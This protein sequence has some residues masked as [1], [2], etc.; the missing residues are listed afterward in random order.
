[1]RMIQMGVA[2]ATIAALATPVF[3]A[4]LAIQ[5]RDR[6]VTYE[7]GSH[8]YERVT[9]HPRVVRRPVV[10]ETVVVRRPLIVEQYPVY[11]VPMYAPPIYAYGGPVWRAR[12]WGPRHFVGG[13]FG[14]PRFHGGHRRFAGR[15]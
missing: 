13:H 8:T 15:W 1:M 9:Q 5:Q 2:A 4:D 11:A 14:G 6:S 3:A 7:R 10:Q 12:V